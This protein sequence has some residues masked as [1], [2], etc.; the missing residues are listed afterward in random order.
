MSRTALPIP[1]YNVEHI[2]QTSWSRHIAYFCKCSLLCLIKIAHS[3][4]CPL[5]CPIL[6]TANCFWQYTYPSSSFSAPTPFLAFLF[7]CQIWWNPGYATVWVS[8]PNESRALVLTFCVVNCQNSSVLGG[9]ELM[10]LVGKNMSWAL[11][12]LAAGLS[13]D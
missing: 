12:Y 1:V 13:K 7:L 10:R 9:E 4:A 6:L 11:P 3:D 2:I 8:L 5:R